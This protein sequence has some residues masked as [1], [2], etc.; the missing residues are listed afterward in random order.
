METKAQT[1]GPLVVNMLTPTHVEAI[2]C[3]VVRVSYGTTWNPKT[4]RFRVMVFSRLCLLG[5]MSSCRTKCYYPLVALVQPPRYASF[6]SG[7]T[8]CRFIGHARF[9]LKSNGTPNARHPPYLQRTSATCKSQSPFGGALGWLSCL[10]N[11]LN[12]CFSS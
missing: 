10:E 1:F 9:L 12:Q 3:S 6:A 5:S 2:K 8:K 7:I 4:M 11:H